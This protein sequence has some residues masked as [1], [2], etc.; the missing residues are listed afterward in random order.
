MKGRGAVVVVALAAVVVLLLVAIGGGDERTNRPFDPTSSGP[1]GARALV[2][3]LEEL[4]ADVEITG[5]GLDDDV[6]TALVLQ[7]RLDEDATDEVEDWVEDGGVL[8]VGD[9][10]SSLFRGGSEGPC[11]AALDSVGVLDLGPGSGTVERGDACFE[12]VVQR[13]DAGLGTVVSIRDRQLLTNQLLGE[14]D[15][16]VLAAALLAPTGRERVAFVVGSAGSGDQALGDLLGPRVAQAIAQL[17]VAALLYALWR[18]RRLGRAVVEPQPVAIA[19]SELVAAVGR[20]QEGRRRPDEVA[21]AVRSDVRRAIERRLGIAAGGDVAPV[22]EAVAARCGMTPE[23]VLGA[24]ERRV[25]T[26]DD[27]LL[28]VLADLDR[29]RAGVLAPLA[30]KQPGG[31]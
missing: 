19:G 5:G 29:I 21:D 9:Q 2:L 23:Q 17:A 27:D 28:A 7:D 30:S 4:G 26:T 20:L 31:T 12:R 10:G 18:A 11:P 14:A 22:A 3:V 13:G 8:V 16:A 1:A 24:L 15:N 6:D 25:V